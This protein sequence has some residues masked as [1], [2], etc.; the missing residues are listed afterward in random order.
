MDAAGTN[1]IDITQVVQERKTSAVERRSKLDECREE[2]GRGLAKALQGSLKPVMA[3]LLNLAERASGRDA[4]RVYMEA[5][6]VARDRSASLSA[7]LRDHFLRAFDAACGESLNLTGG[8]GANDV[9][10]SLVEPDDLEESLAT[11]TFANA[12]NNQCGEELFGLDKRMG[13]L[14][15]DPDLRQ[16]KNPLGP[17]TIAAALMQALREQQ[18]SVKSRLLL[19]AL[20][21]REMPQRVRDVYQDINE[22]LVRR[23]VLPAIRV[24]LKRASRGRDEEKSETADIF[25]ALKQ[26]LTAARSGPGG[27][28]GIVIPPPPMPGEPGFDNTYGAFPARAAPA[29][30]NAAYVSVFMQA[31]DQLQRGQASLPALSGVDMAAITAGRVNVLH[32]LRKSGIASAMDPMDAMTM[33]IVSMMFDYI[34]DDSRIPDAIKALIGRLQIPILKVAIIDKTFFSQRTH[35]ARHLLDTLA[36]AAIGWDESEGH[37]GGL[38]RKV[39]E[40]VQRI[41]DGFE[42][43]MDIFAAAEAEI[44]TYLGEERQQIDRRVRAIK[45]RE[46]EAIA[47]ASA[48]EALLPIL[49]VHPVADVLQAFLDEHWERLLAQ[50]QVQTG[51][52]SEAWQAARQTAEDLVWSVRPKTSQGDR[53]ALLRMLPGLLKRLED[54]LGR[55]AVAREV[56]DGFFATL[57][58]LHAGAVK[59]DAGGSQAGPAEAVPPSEPAGAGP[60]PDLGAPLEVPAEHSAAT[61]DETDFDAATIHI[62]DVDPLVAFDLDEEPADEPPRIERGNWIALRDG[63]GATVRLKLS[64]ISPQGGLYLFTNRL[65]QRAMSIG[66]AGLAAKLRSGEATLIDDVPLVEKAVSQMVG[67]L[68]RRAG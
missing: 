58:R 59:A 43:S 42:D 3:K 30:P 6:D 51:Q 62:P 9:R 16:A 37:E 17:E 31:L 24:G 67:L 47:R 49:A 55:L 44:T 40:L 53:A 48:H 20:L 26:M 35:P 66:A 14:I 52:D 57:V 15:N 21:C 33:D 39:E 1:V 56:R 12:I 11:E 28:D 23:G 54:G 7:G 32:E 22:R 2:S 13:M 29:D 38:Y 63:R 68:Q 36:E 34:L 4:M 60:L 18:V 25:A 50:L 64:W 19:V 27:P 5:L 45:E 10:L 46:E 65:G 8:A 41:L 61:A